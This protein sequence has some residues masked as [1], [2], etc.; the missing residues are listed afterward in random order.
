MLPAVLLGAL[1]SAL[2]TLPLSLPFSATAHDL[3]L[4]GLLGVVLR[5]RAA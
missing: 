3:A 1:M 2:V 4:L 5:R